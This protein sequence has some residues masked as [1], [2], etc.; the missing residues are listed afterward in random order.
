MPRPFP[1]KFITL[2]KGC[3]PPRGREYTYRIDTSELTKEHHDGCVHNR[4]SCARYGEKIQPDEAFQVA[5]LL[6]LIFHGVVHDE[7]LFSVLVQLQ[8]TN[9]L[10][11]LEG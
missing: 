7:E 2:L 6:R 4:A 5:L 11:H 8:P 9:T 3:N 10:P 1:P